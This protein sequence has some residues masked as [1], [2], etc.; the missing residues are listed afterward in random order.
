M[1]TLWRLKVFLL[2]TLFACGAPDEP[3]DAWP[4]R[5]CQAPAPAQ[6]SVSGSTRKDHLLRMDDGVVLALSTRWPKDTDCAGAVVMAP[7]GFEPG[8]KAV[9]EPQIEDLALAGLVVVTW[10]PRGRGD[11]EGEEDMNGERGQDDFAAVLRWSAALS[12]VDSET[13]LVYSRSIGGALASGALGRYPEDLKPIGWVDYE[14]PGW[15]EEDMAHTT[16]HTH[17]RMWALA[18][19]ADDPSAWFDARSPAAF[20][21][22]VVVPY[23]RLQGTPD[24]ALDY[25]GAAL[26]NVNGAV[27][28]PAVYYNGER[29]TEE[30][31]AEDARERAVPG[32]LE[33]GSEYVTEQVLAGFGG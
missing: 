18:E 7:P 14:A 23:R 31:A 24:H 27:S 29:V 20:I 32:G 25:M 4:D 22:D 5:A 1:R 17:D 16:Q 15:L 21:G 30:M 10:D 26:A 28:S 3:P 11:S 13:L 19:T 12:G 2:L 33:P 9:E 6:G 8:T